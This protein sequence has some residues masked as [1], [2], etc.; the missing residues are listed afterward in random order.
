MLAISMDI[1]PRYHHQDLTIPWFG[2]KSLHKRF[3][4]FPQR[5][6]PPMRITDDSLLERVRPFVI[7]VLYKARD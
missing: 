6:F 7:L 4:S 1:R 3:S 2:K 5:S